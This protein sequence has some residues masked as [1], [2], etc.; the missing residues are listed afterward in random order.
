MS[1]PS[2]SREAPR[3]RSEKYNRLRAE[4]ER[5]EQIWQ[6][7]ASN[8]PWSAAVDAHLER[9]W[10]ELGHR[11]YNSG[12]SALHAAR[13]YEL[14]VMVE[15][16]LR[17]HATALEAEA[18]SKLRGWRLTAALELLKPFE[19]RRLPPATVPTVTATATAAALIEPDALRQRLYSVQ[20]L[21]DEHAENCY[22][23]Q[24]LITD[25]AVLLSLMLCAL[26]ALALLNPAAE[27]SRPTPPETWRLALFGAIGAA[28]MGLRSVFG[29]AGEKVPDAVLSAWFTAVRPVIGAAA[30]LVVAY[31][32]TGGIVALSTGSHDAMLAL[33]FIAGLSDA[34]V[35]RV[36]GAFDNG[37]SDA[38]KKDRSPK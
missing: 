5:F 28:F 18:R 34:L 25:R 37:T 3:L 24:K 15:H 35:V 23:K 38:P 8:Q 1:R 19:S 26:L 29:A 21:V 7:S 4:I 10:F 30:A 32:Q 17:N 11:Q 13:R 12:W 14:F 16:R 36:I 20:T 27:G 9:A 22:F 33:A 31:A 6:R 2:P